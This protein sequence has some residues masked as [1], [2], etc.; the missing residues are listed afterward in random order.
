VGAAEPGSLIMQM[1]ID[2]LPAILPDLMMNIESATSLFDSLVTLIG[3]RKQQASAPAPAL[4]VVPASLVSVNGNNNLVVAL[5][6]DARVDG[7][8]AAL[9]EPLTSR[10]IDTMQLSKGGQVVQEVTKAEAYEMVRHKKSQ[11]ASQQQHVWRGN[12]TIVSPS[13]AKRRSWV[14]DEGDGSEPFKAPMRDGAFQEKV[15]RREKSFQAGDTLDATMRTTVH[16][17]GHMVV[18]TTHEITEVH[19]VQTLPPPQQQ[20]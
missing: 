13:F 16:M 14:L 6:G 17:R 5:Q 19:N 10:G 3:M 11:P 18:K 7:L 20:Y 8:V 4:P 1:M 12:F 15:L 9:V 2:Q